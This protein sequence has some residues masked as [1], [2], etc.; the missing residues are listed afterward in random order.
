MNMEKVVIAAIA[1]N[2]VLGKDGSLLWNLPDD[3]EHLLSLIQKGWL[4]TGRTSYESA[5]GSRIF[6]DRDDVLVLTS[7]EDYSLEQGKVVHHLSDAYRVAEEAG[8][9]YLFILGGAKVYQQTLEEADRMVLTIVDETF[10]GDAFFPDW[11]SSNWKETKRVFHPRDE[12]H[13][14]PFSIVWMDH[15]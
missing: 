1:K 5:Q 6:A 8:A 7:R 13:D 10:E 2:R 3:E 11:T 14:F 9:N 12:E 15:L 4:L